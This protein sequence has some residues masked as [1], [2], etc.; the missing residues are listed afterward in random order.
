LG[1]PLASQLTEFCAENY[2]KKTDVV[3][4]ALTGYFERWAEQQEKK[5]S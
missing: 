5:G 1:E 2:R 4:E 3:R